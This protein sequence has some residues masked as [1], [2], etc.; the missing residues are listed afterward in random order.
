MSQKLK[1]LLPLGILAVSI[2]GALVIVASKPDIQPQTREIPPKLVRV[3]SV[4]KQTIQMTIVSQGTVTPRTASA[5]VAQVAGRI[6]A[7]SPSFVAGGFFEKGDILISL[8]QSDYDLAVIQAKYQVAQAELTLQLEEQQAEIAREEWQ[9]LNDGDIPSL[10]AREPQLK[11]AKAALEA[12]KATLYQTKL[13]LQRTHIRAPFAGRVRA[14]NADVGQYVTQGIAL[15]QIYAIDYAEVRL[16]LP[17]S[18][19]AF[20]DMPF[21]FRG[22]EPLQKGPRVKLKA[23]FAGKAQEWQ[24]YLTHIEAEIDPRSRMV[25][26]VA[27]VE[28][29]YGKSKSKVPLP[30]GL[31]VQAEISGKKIKDV[32]V[33]PRSALRNENQM[34]VLDAENRLRFRQVEILKT[35]AE[36]VYILEGLK[37]GEQVCISPLEAAIDGMP[38]KPFDEQ[39]ANNLNQEKKQ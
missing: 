25:H 33:L 24:G 31:F 11:Q 8:D 7:V 17:D 32:A 5:L 13:N 30:V 3:L 9:Q 27:Q 36:N 28:N 18:E 15:A 35:D 1:Y 29:P 6:T 20:L 38:V 2:L 19:L 39:A 16:P 4:K 34:L 26:V 12:A 10:V 37:N 23:N 22:T 14:K 21:D